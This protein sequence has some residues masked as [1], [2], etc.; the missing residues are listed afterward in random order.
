MD[1][2]INSIQSE[3]THEFTVKMDQIKRANSQ[4]NNKSFI[5]KDI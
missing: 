2:N 5:T 4:N 3:L 1:A